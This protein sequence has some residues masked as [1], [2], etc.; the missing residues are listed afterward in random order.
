M[1][2]AVKTVFGL[3][4]AILVLTVAAGVSIDA[5]SA[6]IAPTEVFDGTRYIAHR[7]LSSVY[8]QN[9]YEAFVGAAESDYFWGV[10]TDIWRT[11][12]GVWV[13]THDENPFEDEDLL[14]SELSYDVVQGTPLS[15]KKAGEYVEYTDEVYLSTLSEYL[16][17][18][19][20]YGKAAVIELKAVYD[21]ETL[22]ELLAYVFS[23][24]DK[25][26]VCFISFQT[27]NIK[28]INKIDNEVS[29]MALAGSGK[30]RDFLIAL[31]YPVNINKNILSASV[32]YRAHNKGNT[33]AVY[34]VNDK[35][36][37]EKYAAMGVDYVTTD[38]DFSKEQTL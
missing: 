29:V 1:N 11:T 20:S 32:I 28:N 15:S 27:E 4:C 37:V 22:A 6:N 25:K 5:L 36:D 2:N 8:Y 33:V 38:F 30:R 34:T 17:V 24:A 12:D 26:D 31:D 13:C 7:G 3:V 35:K 23:R 21:K 19:V 9:S 18:C 16:G 10:E 14:V